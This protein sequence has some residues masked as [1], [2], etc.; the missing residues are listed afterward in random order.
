MKHVP[1][2]SCIVCRQVKDKSDLLR[3]VR[4]PDGE[5]ALDVTGREAGRGAYV[6]RHGEC[7]STMEKK[8]ALARAFKQEV[9]QDVYDKLLREYG[10]LGAND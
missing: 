8:R 10:S 6:C 3:I 2:R 7:M 4:K 1:M 9:T 5:I